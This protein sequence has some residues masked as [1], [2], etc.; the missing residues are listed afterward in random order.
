MLLTVTLV[1]SVRMV[2]VLHPAVC[3]ILTVNQTKNAY[4]ED[5]LISVQE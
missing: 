1:S 2:N 4:K 3:Q 5:A